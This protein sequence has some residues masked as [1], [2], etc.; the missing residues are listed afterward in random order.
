MRKLLILSILVTITFHFMCGCG[1]VD[2]AV[3]KLKNLTNSVTVDC[4]VTEIDIFMENEFGT[5][6]AH[7]SFDTPYSVD[8]DEL[9]NWL[10]SFNGGEFEIEGISVLCNENYYM[11][12]RYFIGVS[13]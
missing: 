2:N 12:Q 7:V 4:G 6:T 9:R 13:E 3:E 1:T 5:N 10:L 11:T 8:V